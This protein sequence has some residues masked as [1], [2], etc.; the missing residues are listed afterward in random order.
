MPGRGYGKAPN[1]GAILKSIKASFR[2][3]ARSRCS[4]RRDQLGADD[5][6]ARVQR[7]FIRQTIDLGGETQKVD[8]DV[9]VLAGPALPPASI[10]LSPR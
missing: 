3:H 8:T 9:N 10:M 6:D 7:Y 2:R 1:C 4:E 5:P